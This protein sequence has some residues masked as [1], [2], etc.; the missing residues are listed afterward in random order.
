VHMTP[1][2]AATKAS[3]ANGHANGNDA[4]AKAPTKAKARAN[5]RGGF[6]LDMT[7]GGA[8]ARDA[9]FERV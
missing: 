7:S 9:E 4:V 2:P 5:G 3:K 8:D 1:K 6:S